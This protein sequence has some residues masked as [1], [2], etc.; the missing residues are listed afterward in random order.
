MTPVMHGPGE[1]RQEVRESE[2]VTIDSSRRL[3]AKYGGPGP[4][5]TSY[6]PATEWSSAVGPDEHRAALARAGTREGEP[7]SLYVHVPFCRSLCLYCGCN[8][9]VTRSEARRSEY[10]KTLAREIRLVADALG[11]RRGVSTL[12]LGGGSP[13]WLPPR[14]L[15][16]VFD[17]IGSS[18][19]VASDAEIAVELDPR[20]LDEALLDLL[21]SVGVNR[22]SLGVQDLDPAVQQAVARIQPEARTRRLVEHAQR[23]RFSSISIDLM[24]GLPRQTAASFAHTLDAVVEMAPDRVSVFPYAHV[25][26]LRP[27]Q[28]VLEKAGLPGVD[29]RMELATLARD[30]LLGEGFVAI[31]MDH[32]ARP[33]DALAIAWR[34]GRLHRNFQGY[35]VGPARDLVG[36]G[37]SAI[38]DVDG[39]YA[40]NAR[41][42]RVWSVTIESGSFATDRGFSLSSE[43]RLRREVILALLC[44]FHVDL[45]A[46][47]RRWGISFADH[48]ADALGALEPLAEDGLVVLGPDSIEV[49]DAGRPFARAAAMAFDELAARRTAAARTAFSRIA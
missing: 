37:P 8:V 11:R 24:T 14:A 35:T 18:F 46:I 7:L 19:T 36:L 33:D 43:D 31:G 3:A 32:F 21:R 17:A 38:S 2:R 47:E 26:W 49:T 25:P 42:E 23:L 22:I 27:H 1:E 40:Q 28:R 6:P 20:P 15:L 48:F 44:E 13:N 30:R 9:V 5:Y 29:L 34:A 39:V 41:E 12:H 45:R 4:R 10:A 16:A